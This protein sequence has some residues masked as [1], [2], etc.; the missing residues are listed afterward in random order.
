MCGR[1]L[2]NPRPSRARTL[3]PSDACRLRAAQ[4]CTF[5]S[6]LDRL[7]KAVTWEQLD[8]LMAEVVAFPNGA[9]DFEAQG[10]GATSMGGYGLSK[11]LLNAYLSCVA[12]EQ[13][14]PRPP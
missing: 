6:R 14:R 9:K 8:A 7:D 12:R 1:D 4:G 10:F 11:A 3:D 5:E 13:P 2:L